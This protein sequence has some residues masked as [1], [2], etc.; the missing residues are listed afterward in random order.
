[1]FNLFL[2]ILISA[3]AIF[4]AAYLLPGVTVDS[5]GEAV[6]VSIILGLLNALV[7]PVLTILTIPITILTLGLFLI[8]IDALIILLAAHL[9]EGFAVDG[10][11]W[12]V[13]FSLAVSIFSS[14][15][16]ALLD[17]KK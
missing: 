4:A 3:F 5:F 9:L 6:L 13:I 8:V 15:T 12:A 11:L 1:M 10:L 7:K 14:I 17:E 2:K 16:Y